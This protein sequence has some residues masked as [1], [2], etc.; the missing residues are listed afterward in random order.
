[1]GERRRIT[2]WLS[3]A[4]IERLQRWSD[5]RRVP[6]GTLLERIVMAES[7]SDALGDLRG[8]PMEPNNYMITR[9]GVTKSA[10]HWGRELGI[11]RVTV[12][13]RILEGLTDDEILS[14]EDLTYK[15]HDKK[16]RKGGGTT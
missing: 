8:N 7:A 14:V 2:V 6:K 13:W 4:A 12:R 10:W 11:P 16:K 1:M 15:I 9:G 3:D 5:E